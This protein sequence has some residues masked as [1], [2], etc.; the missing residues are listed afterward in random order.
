MWWRRVDRVVGLGL[1]G[2]RRCERS[3][4]VESGLV[5]GRPMVVRRNV[6]VEVEGLWLMRSLLIQSGLGFLC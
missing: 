2:V 3:R 5:M 1:G 4:L 6:S